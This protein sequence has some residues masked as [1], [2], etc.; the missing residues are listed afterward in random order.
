MTAETESVRVVDRIHARTIPR[1]PRLGD[2]VPFSHGGD[3]TQ[4]SRFSLILA[5]LPRRLRR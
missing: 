1:T 4:A 2:L 5:A 3:A